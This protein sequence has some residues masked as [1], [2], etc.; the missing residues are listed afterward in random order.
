M[1]VFDVSSPQSI[2]ILAGF[3]SFVE[4]GIMRPPSF[5]GNFREVKEPGSNYFPIPAD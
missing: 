4:S 3:A 5:R 1:I 2:W